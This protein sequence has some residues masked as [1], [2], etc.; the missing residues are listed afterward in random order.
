MVARHARTRSGVLDAIFKTPRYRREERETRERAEKALSFFGSRLMGYRMDQTATSLS[1]ANRRRLEMARA[2]GSDPQLLL[3][4]E[5]TAGMNPR[6]TKELT[7]LIGKMRD[8]EGLT[9]LVIEHDMQVVRGVSD[10]VA[11]LDYGRKIAE[12]DFDTVA[13]DEQVIEAYLGR[14]ADAG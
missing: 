1:Y 6:E 10:R 7:T 4:D 8:D 3:L 13:A 11:V 14:S 12:G 9:I 5:P 2:M